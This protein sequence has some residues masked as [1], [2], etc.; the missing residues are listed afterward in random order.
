[1][2]KPLT[3]KTL[4][5]IKH[6]G[7]ARGLVGEIVGRYER[8]GLK[9][10]A[11]K[12]LH[13]SKDLAAK[14]YTSTDEDHARRGNNTLRDAAEK[15]VDV[16]VKFNTQ[17]PI[18]IGKKINDWLIDYINEG[19]VVAFV[20]EG[21]SAIKVARKITGSTL[22]NEAASG[23]IRGDLTHDN[24]ELANFHDRPMRNLV[25]ASGNPQEAEVEINLWFAKEEVFDYPRVDEESMFGPLKP[26]K[27]Q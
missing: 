16:N 9:V 3:E 17:D 25:H 7:V 1:M 24:P 27:S 26:V 13:A 18:E 2:N 15:G 19:P 22:P 4:V 14:H 23:T 8:A 12:L 5:V 20:L 11:M 21:Y 6:D 10:V